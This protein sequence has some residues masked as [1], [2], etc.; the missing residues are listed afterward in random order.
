MRFA[1]T[2]HSRS[3]APDDALELLWKRVDGRRFEDVGFRRSGPDLIA[4]IDNDAPIGREGDERHEADRLAVLACLR[5]VCERAPELDADW[6]AV[7][8]GR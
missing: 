7:T 4:R 1:V 3:G 5:E 8:Q 6:F 2:K